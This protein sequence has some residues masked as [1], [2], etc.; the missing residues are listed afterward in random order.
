MQGG[1]KGAYG[2]FLTKMVSRAEVRMAFLRH[3]LEV[4]DKLWASKVITTTTVNT[5]G[6]TSRS[7]TSSGSM[8]ATSILKLMDAKALFK[9]AFPVM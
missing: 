4:F 3:L 6:R 5:L 1:V 7:A 2:G 9:K 8:P